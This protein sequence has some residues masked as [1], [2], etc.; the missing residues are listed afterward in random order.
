MPGGG[1]DRPSRLL[2]WAS[3]LI[4]GLARVA[5]D[6]RVRDYTTGNIVAP[7]QLIVELGLRG[8]YGEYCIALL[9][10]ALRGGHHVVE[11]PYRLV[12]RTHG[13]SKTSRSGASVRI[14]GGS[15]GACSRNSGTPQVPA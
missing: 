12:S 9:A 5:I 15:V 3:V 2:R 10:D 11:L 7:R 13:E 14:A 6:R 4:N 8:D 1:D